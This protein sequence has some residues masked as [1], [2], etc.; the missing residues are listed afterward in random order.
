VEP[1]AI[2]HLASEVEP[3]DIL[4]GVVDFFTGIFD[5]IIDLLGKLFDF[6][7]FF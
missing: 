5:F 3:M 2:R 6:L 4:D 7:P 1:N